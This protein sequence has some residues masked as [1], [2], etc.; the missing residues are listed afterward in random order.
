[1][2]PAK[3]LSELEKAE[4][5]RVYRVQP[6]DR[7]TGPFKPLRR[8]RFFGPLR[9]CV[10]L[11]CS[12]AFAITVFA[13]NTTEDRCRA[14]QERLALLEKQDKT[15]QREID[16]T[17]RDEDYWRDRLSDANKAAADPENPTLLRSLFYGDNR[18]GDKLKLIL[19]SWGIE[20]KVEYENNDRALFRVMRDSF[21]AHVERIKYV[22]AHKGDIQREKANVD[23]LI[24][25]HR[26]RLAEL[27]CDTGTAT[28]DPALAARLHL[29]AGTWYAGSKTQCW[30]MNVSVSGTNITGSTA[31]NGPFVDTTTFKGTW[32]GAE[33]VAN[34]T[35]KYNNPGC[36]SCKATQGSRAGRTVLKYDESGRT[37]HMVSTEA[38]ESEV[39]SGGRV[40]SGRYLKTPCQ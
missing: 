27:A 29:F 37:L 35:G 20:W 14:N 8:S 25:Y 22:L 9:V 16:Y 3:T 19:S 11:G 12:I 30:Q 26:N 10:T 32:T 33:F 13:Q 2:S 15:L 34:W 5:V 24:S 39:F 17:P 4:L 40:F 21:A 28:V 7:S 38:K 23:G 31:L 18:S 1:M 6:R 36:A